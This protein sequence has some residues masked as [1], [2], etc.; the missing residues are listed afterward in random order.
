MDNNY[1][2]SILLEVILYSRMKFQYLLI[3]H[4]E[5]HGCWWPGDA[6]SQGIVIDLDCEEYSIFIIQRVFFFI[7]YQLRIFC[8]HQLILFFLSYLLINP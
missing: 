7:I 8:I 2:D 4:G 1:I 5:H 6:R 3:L